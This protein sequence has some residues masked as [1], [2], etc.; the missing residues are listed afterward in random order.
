MNFRCYDQLSLKL[1]DGGGIFVGKNAQGKT[2]ILEAI[3][4]LMRLQSPRS[5]KP[6]DFV[7]FD[8]NFCGVSG[9]YQNRDY[10]FAYGQLDV[11]KRGA[12]AEFRVDG[13]IVKKNAD[14]L[15]DSGL[16][17]W[18]G[19]ADLELIRGGGEGRRRYLDFLGVQLS[20]EYRLSLRRYVRALKSRNA[21]LK[22]KMKVA[23]PRGD[24]EMS[25]L[26]AFTNILIEDGEKLSIFRRELIGWLNPFVAAAMAKIS[27][28]EENLSLVYRSSIKESFREELE[29]SFER[30]SRMGITSVGPHRD[31]IILKVNDLKVKDFGS[32]GPATL[33][34]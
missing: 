29:H 10:R 16:V 11:K 23:S 25:S 20:P 22:V 15:Q 2:S 27:E 21:L 5:N 32:E 33:S 17:V 24:D 18:M 30:D 9:E 12:I 1:A 14:Y 4:V 19:N 13:D 7:Q 6:Q 8:Q 31:E 3:C 26:Q 28:T 34:Y